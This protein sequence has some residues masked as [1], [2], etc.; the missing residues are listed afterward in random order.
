MDWLRAIRCSDPLKI[1]KNTG[2]GPRTCQ[3]RD[4]TRLSKIRLVSRT[5]GDILMSASGLISV[6]TE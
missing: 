2:P 1:R 6:L 5:F 4:S 3:P